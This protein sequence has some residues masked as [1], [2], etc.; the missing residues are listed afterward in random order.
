MGYKHRPPELPQT[1]KDIT[2][3]YTYLPTYGFPTRRTSS[4]G[5]ITHEKRTLETINRCTVRDKTVN[6]GARYGT[7]TTG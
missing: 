7:K 2:P 5:L 6:T 1:I 4:E 3:K